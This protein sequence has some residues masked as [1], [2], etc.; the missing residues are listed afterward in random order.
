MALE[1]GTLCS[2][3]RQDQL[4]GLFHADAAVI[5][6][7]LPCHLDCRKV[8]TTGLCRLLDTLDH[9]FQQG[10]ISHAVLQL[11]HDIFR[12]AAHLFFKISCFIDLSHQLLHHGT[13]VPAGGISVPG[14]HV[15]PV[16][17]DA[18]DLQHDAVAVVGYLDLRVDAQQHHAHALSS[19]F[20]R[21]RLGLWL[22][23]CPAAAEDCRQE[24]G[25]H[26]K[27]PYFFPSHRFHHSFSYLSFFRFALV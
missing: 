9:L 19:R 11:H 1:G 8:Q 23:L 15:P 5:I 7:V 10:R 17:I 25:G 20:L 16:I 3:L 4:L 14:H 6:Q 2:Q 18:L 26:R 13:A 12:A 22:R 24:R 27:G 21:H